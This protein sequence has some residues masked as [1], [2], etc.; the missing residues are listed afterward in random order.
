MD[1]HKNNRSQAPVESVGIV[2]HTFKVA[3]ELF[4]RIEQQVQ[5]LKQY[6]NRSYSKQMWI[7]E[8]FKERLEREKN[9]NAEDL[10]KEAIIGFRIDEQISD[11]ILLH[12]QK[13]RQYRHAFSKKQWMIEAFYEKLIKDEKKA[14]S[15]LKKMKNN[16]S[17]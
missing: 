8:A 11:K 12:V 10:G 14:K 4:T 13:T 1:N 7:I 6:N 2:N 3:E 9:L 17:S 15:L 16:S 5:F